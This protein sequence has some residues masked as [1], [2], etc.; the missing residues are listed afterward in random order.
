MVTLAACCATAPPHEGSVVATP[1]ADLYI[2]AEAH[3]GTNIATDTFCVGCNSQANKMRALLRFDLSEVPAGATVTAATLE[4][5]VLRA[6]TKGNDVRVFPIREPWATT[7]GGGP[8]GPTW[9][10]RSPTLGDWSLPGG[11]LATAPSGSV[12]MDGPARYSVSA[13]GLINDV[14]RWIGDPASNHG[15]ALVGDETRAPT[16]K[17]IASS[18]HENEA[19]R[20]RLIVRYERR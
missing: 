7:P 17:R 20:P 1:A 14:Q 5:S 13:D 2:V 16:V 12:T 9:E 4:V 18:R 8:E 11:A 19:A 15:W 10:T 6:R 3:T